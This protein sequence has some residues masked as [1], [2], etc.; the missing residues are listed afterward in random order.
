MRNMAM[1]NRKDREFQDRFAAMLAKHDGKKVSAEGGTVDTEGACYDADTSFVSENGDGYRSPMD[2][3]MGDIG[4]EGHHSSGDHVANEREDH[5]KKR[6]PAESHV[7]HGSSNEDGDISGFEAPRSSRRT[8]GFREAYKEREE[9]L[10]KLSADIAEYKVCQ[11]SDLHDRILIS[12][13]PR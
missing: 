10:A 7:R 3:N 13:C 9:K 2:E 12:D 8:P 11:E 4:E 1:K 6:R 5:R